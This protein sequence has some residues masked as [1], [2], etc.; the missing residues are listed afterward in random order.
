MQLPE[1]FSAK[2]AEVIGDSKISPL[3]ARAP[4]RVEVLGNHTDYNGGDVLAATIDRYVWAAGI[5]SGEVEIHSLDSDDVVAFNPHSIGPSSHLSWKSYAKGVYWAF[6]RRMHNVS[7]VT[8]VIQGNIPQGAG[9]SSSAAFEVAL[10]NLVLSASNI[11]LN[12][13]AIAMLAFEAERIYCGVACGVMDQFTSQLGK[14]NSL[15][16]IK[17]SNLVTGDIPWNPQLKLVI[18]NSGFQRAA[19]EVLNDRR[20]ECQQALQILLEESWA[21]SNIS[22][23]QPDRLDAV[24]DLLDET[25]ARRVMHVVLENER[26]KSGVKAL[27]DGRFEDFG[28]LMYESHASSRDLYE[29][30]HPNLDTLVEIAKSKNGVLGSRLTGAGLGGATL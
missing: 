27:R 7:G 17:C 11:R 25:L 19:V 2:M 15:L 3:V 9:L 10:A 26:V 20:L 4:G 1:R 24:S 21:A 13:K 23:L 8:G 29:V 6:Q 18:I 30:S 28:A 12:P 22:E 16:A 5:P 14:P